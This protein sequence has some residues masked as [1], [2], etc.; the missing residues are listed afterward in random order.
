MGM[1]LYPIAPGL[2][3]T[4]C[5]AGHNDDAMD[6]IFFSVQILDFA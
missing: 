3:M 6:E 1:Y 4:N 5:S 2:K